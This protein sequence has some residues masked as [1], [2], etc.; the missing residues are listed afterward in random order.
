MEPGASH[1]IPKMNIL[2]NYKTAGIQQ[3]LADGKDRGG[4]HT[5]HQQK[6]QIEYINA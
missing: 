3:H 4:W 1:Q 6:I 2:I 5:F